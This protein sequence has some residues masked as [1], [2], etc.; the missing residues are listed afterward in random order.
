MLPVLQAKLIHGIRSHC[1][2]PSRMREMK[3]T[4]AGANNIL[5]DPGALTEVCFLRENS[6]S[7]KL[8]ICVFSYYI[9]YI[10]IYI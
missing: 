9:L 2:V 7:Y 5:P 3:V 10:H 8:L 4:S 1:T 6:F